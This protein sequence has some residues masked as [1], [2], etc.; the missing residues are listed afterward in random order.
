M[1]INQID[2]SYKELSYYK[3]DYTFAVTT[4]GY[5]SFPWNV[6]QLLWK[7]ST[8]IGIGIG[9]YFQ[10][11]STNNMVSVFSRNWFNPAGNVPYQY[12][13]NVFSPK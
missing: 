1:G 7:S 8:S 5:P 13:N 9:G 10:S 12:A 4:N 6:A 11:T 3:T 2:Q